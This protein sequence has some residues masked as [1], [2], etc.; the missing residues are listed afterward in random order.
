MEPTYERERRFLVED[1]SIVEHAVAWQK[2]S[3]AYIFAVDGFTVRVRLV[4]QPGSDAAGRP[5]MEETAWLTGKGPRRPDGT[6][7][8]YDTLVTP[9]WARGI[10]DRS[11]NV[12]EKTRYQVVQGENETWEIDEFLDAGNRGLW[13]AE[14]EVE[15]EAGLRAVRK[16]SWAAKEVTSDRRYNNDELA[17]LP[18]NE[19]A[20]TEEVLDEDADDYRP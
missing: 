3:Q 6:R 10:I 2:L 15:S 13:V 5:V 14:I 11:G 19:W 7:E 8:E 20:H 17:L 18:W 16:P 4:Q 9:L 1:T 12:I